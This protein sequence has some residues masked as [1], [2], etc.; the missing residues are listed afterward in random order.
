[1]IN[2]KWVFGLENLSE[3]HKIREKVFKDELGHKIIK[4]S[5]DDMA[6]HVLV[7]EDDQYFASGRVFDSD[8]K[9]QI[10]MI[11]VDKRVRGRHL[12]SLVARLL[13]NRGFEL[14]ANK[15]HTNAREDSVEFYEK[16]NFEVCGDEYTDRNGEQT[17][18]MVLQKE[19]SPLEGG[20]SSCDSCENGCSGK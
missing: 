8:G 11:C 7:G 16:L 10:D 13:I 12:G 15:I 14:L 17:I 5:D 6:L 9:F 19:N 3:V 2:S 1:M 4:D 18:P 20:C